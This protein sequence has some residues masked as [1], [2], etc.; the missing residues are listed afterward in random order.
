[1]K[2]ARIL[3]RDAVAGDKSMI[4]VRGSADS[5]AKAFE[6][7]PPEFAAAQRADCAGAKP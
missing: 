7:L 3:G 5:L 1:M 4:E 6:N 2:S